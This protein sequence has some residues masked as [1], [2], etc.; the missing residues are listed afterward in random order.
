MFYPVITVLRD[1][2]RLMWSVGRKSPSISTQ[3]KN[4]ENELNKA[5]PADC[6]IR[7]LCNFL[8]R[9]P[10]AGEKRF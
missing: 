7:D 4:K 3:G 2:L 1:F 5:R 10:Q 9:L 8:K 6:R